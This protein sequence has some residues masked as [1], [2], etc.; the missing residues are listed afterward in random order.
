MK[1]FDRV[2]GQMLAVVNDGFV[3]VIETAFDHECADEA[4]HFVRCWFAERASRGNEKPFY[5]M[6]ED[7]VNGVPI[8]VD[9]DV[10]W[11]CSQDCEGKYGDASQVLF[12]RLRAAQYHEWKLAAEGDYALQINI[13]RI[14]AIRFRR[15]NSIHNTAAILRNSL[16]ESTMLQQALERDLQDLGRKVDKLEDELDASRRDN[17]F[18]RNDMGYWQKS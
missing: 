7:C 9:I 8:V 16:R 3:F 17:G 14:R 4:D 15:D 1:N 13:D 10:I 12:V 18:A 5:P 6:P 11:N 2:K